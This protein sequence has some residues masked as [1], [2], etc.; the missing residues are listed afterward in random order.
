MRRLRVENMRY[1]L[2]RGA[3]LGLRLLSM[4][5]KFLLV[6]GLGKY[7]GIEA[8]GE[9]ALFSTSIIIFIYL[10]GLDFY[11]FSSRE[12]LAIE[13]GNKRIEMIKNQFIF[14]CI[15]YL[16]AFPVVFVFFLWGIIP[17]KYIAI[18]CMI[19]VFEH[20]SQEFYRLF[21][22]LSHPVVANMVLLLRAGIWCYVLLL[23][24]LFQFDFA[25]YIEN[26]YLL[27]FFGAFVAFLISLFFLNNKFPFSKLS[28][29]I[30]WGW[31][32]LGVK[33]SF[34]FFIATLGIKIME[35]SNRYFI[36]YFMDK[37]DVGIFVFYSNI[38]SAIQ[39][40][41]YTLVVIIYF[42]K[43]V[44]EL[45]ADKYTSSTIVK[46]FAKE[47]IIYT[48]VA[49]VFTVLII[50][51][52]LGY[53]GKAQL[54]EYKYI[55]WILLINSLVINL[56][57]IPHYALFAYHKDI[58]LRNITLFSSFISIV[59]N[60]IFIQLWGLTGAAIAILIPFVFMGSLKYIFYQ[61]ELRGQKNVF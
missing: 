37:S 52:V 32:L 42:P 6:A 44:S 61:K 8:L 30:D 38:S 22:T 21:I 48:M 18:F 15:S 59:M 20:I 31:I 29:Q 57:L 46:E 2:T 41:V 3:N 23:G 16:I 56:S 50:D 17:D 55:L 7:V 9:Y 25:F 36:D 40:I 53:V 10:I 60:L 1:L 47:I 39:T 27:W 26:I 58:L 43:M 5:A 24:W 45:Q 11:T 34:P 14:H 12:I 4:G 13:D 35:F 33:K 28:K 49:I 51:N 54:V 19:L